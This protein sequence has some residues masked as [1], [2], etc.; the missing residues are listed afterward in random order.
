MLAA[1]GRAQHPHR[2]VMVERTISRR[3]A[4]R[5]AFVL[6]YQHDLLDE[7][8]ESLIAR[9]AVDDPTPVSDFTREV[10]AGVVANKTAID[11][12]IDRRADGWT[13]ERLGTVERA[14]LRLA[15]WELEHGDAP[16]AV[17]VSEAVALARRY[18]SPEAAAFV[19][20]LL[21]RVARDRGE[22]A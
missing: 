2:H 5:A 3:Q 6:L 4:R 22:D 16:A 9:R 8:A 13:A 19:N 20:G 11:A 7:A 21:G 12:L 17:V 15:L 14:V 10:V 1:R 18:A